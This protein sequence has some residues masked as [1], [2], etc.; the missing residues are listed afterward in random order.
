MQKYPGKMTGNSTECKCKSTKRMDAKTSL[1]PVAPN[2][3]NPNDH[4]N[5]LNY[6]TEKFMKRDSLQVLSI[7]FHHS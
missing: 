2:P 1:T 4:H 6:G 5:L 3:R 7:S